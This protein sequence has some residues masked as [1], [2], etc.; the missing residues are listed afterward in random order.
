MFSVKSQIANIL[1]L[2][3]LQSLTTTHLC[4]FSMKTAIDNKQQMGVT[5]FQYNFIYQNRQWQ[6]L[7]HM[8]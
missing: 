8:S 4:L 1:G 5:M 2:K 6:D 7:T 3:V